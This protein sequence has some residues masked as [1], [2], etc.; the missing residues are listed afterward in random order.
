MASLVS[1]AM[2]QTDAGRH[3]NIIPLA[4]DSVIIP[5]SGNYTL[6]EDSCAE[7][8][9]YAKFDNDTRI[10]TGKFKDVRKDNPS[11][12]L[13]EGNYDEDGLK[14]GDFTAYYPDGKLQAK[15]SFKDDNYAGRWDFYYPDGKPEINFEVIAGKINIINSWDEKHNKNVDNGRGV[16][17]ARGLYNYYWRGNIVK[18]RPDGIWKMINVNNPDMAPIMTERFKN[19]VFIIGGNASMNYS[20][21]SHITLVKPD[22]LPFIMGE[23]MRISPYRCVLMP[24]LKNNYV[25]ATYPGGT[26]A[27]SEDIKSVISSF[28]ENDIRGFYKGLSFSIEGEISEKGFLVNLKTSSSEN[29]ARKILMQLPQLQALKPATIDGKPVKQNFK[30]E[31]NID[32]RGYSF[33]YNFLSLIKP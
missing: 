22:K 33:H 10:F 25:S 26:D 5:F 9:R 6:I 7:I 20:D 23:K 12:V 21:S 3:I 15:G 31:F 14:D 17:Q 19:N 1:P 29:V 32:S 13:A 24:I 30:I 16:Y 18:G 11:I 2:A 27:F 8:L 28:I 4:K